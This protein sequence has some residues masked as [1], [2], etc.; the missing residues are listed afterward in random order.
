M[1]LN[2][3]IYLAFAGLF[4]ISTFLIIP[5]LFYIRNTRIKKMDKVVYGFEFPNDNIFAMFFRVPEYSLIFLSK[6]Y[7]KKNGFEEKVA[8][9][10]KHFR[11]PFIAV[12]LLSAF[13]VFLIII[14]TL[15]KKY[16]I[17]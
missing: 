2:Q 10:D 15:F 16:V 7:T 11:W 5:L 9:L 17:E 12:S 6:L 8:H 4:V 14:M 3:V 13:N 1:P